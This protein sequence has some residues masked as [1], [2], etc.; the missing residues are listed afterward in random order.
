M[1]RAILVF[2]QIMVSLGETVQN[3]GE[4]NGGKRCRSRSSGF[5]SVGHNDA[6]WH[7]AFR[8]RAHVARRKRR[9]RVVPIEVRDSEIAALV[10]H[11]FLKDDR[12]DDPRA[13]GDALGRLLDQ[14]L[15]KQWPMV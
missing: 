14:I 9:E 12:K 6:G 8:C 5:G 3:V 1:S 11:G 10:A 15:P 2:F 13:I 7:A 4:N